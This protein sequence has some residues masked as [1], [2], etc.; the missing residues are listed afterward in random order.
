[1]SSVLSW[2]FLDQ[3]SITKVYFYSSFFTGT[4]DSLAIMGPL[5]ASN[6]SFVSLDRLFDLAELV[7]DPQ[8]SIHMTYCE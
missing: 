3:I 7:E 2:P 4:R 6:C 1:M 5:D 8:F